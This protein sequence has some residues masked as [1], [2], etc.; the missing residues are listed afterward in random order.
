M[1]EKV[2]AFSPNRA[3]LTRLVSEQSSSGNQVMAAF[4]NLES[5]QDYGRR[6]P[7]RMVGE[8]TS[9]AAP[10]TVEAPVFPEQAPAPSFEPSAAPPVPWEAAEGAVAPPPA[11][12]APM[13]APVP[14]APPMLAMPSMPSMPVVAVPGQLDAVQP[15]KSGGKGQVFACYSPR[16][17]SGTSLLAAALASK[18]AQD[19]QLR[20]LLVD[21]DLQNGS[22]SYFFDVTEMKRSSVLGLKPLIDEILVRAEGHME[23]VPAEAGAVISEEIL[24]NKCFRKDNLYVLC[25]L[26]DPA[27]IDDYS[28]PSTHMEALVQVLSNNFDVVVLDLPNTVDMFT[29]PALF[30]S[31]RILVVT[32]DDVPSQIKV[33]RM[34]NLVLGPMIEAR[35]LRV[36][37]RCFL[38]VNRSTKKKL[39]VPMPVAVAATIPDDKKFMES[40]VEKHE[41]YTKMAGSG[42]GKAVAQLATF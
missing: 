35:D 9:V 23:R 19:P 38:V 7:Y 39:E 18:I 13:A 31:D 33:A 10:P 5:A 12:E 2:V 40:F 37:D 16:G 4:L 42:V 30:Q 24:L 26:D 25:A 34:L 11:F 41:P 15:R 1:T 29:A 32:P 3:R 21:L 14:T 6:H 8:A 17:G 27:A 22:Q 28:D 20:V 36:Q